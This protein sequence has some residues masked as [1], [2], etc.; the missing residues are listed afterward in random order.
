MRKI[1][2]LAFSLL[3]FLFSLSSL[4]SKIYAAAEDL[5]ASS[6]SK[7]EVNYEL[8]YPGLLPDNPLYFLRA[9]R[10]RVVSFL[11]ADP[12]K[13]AEFNLLQADK[14]LNAGIYLFDKNKV[15]LSISTISKAEN[16]FEEAL[17]KTREA[18]Q[19][20]MVVSDIAGR[21]RD[22][23]RKHQKE[24]YLLSQKSP[25]SFKANFESQRKR[26]ANFEIEAESLRLK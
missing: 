20:G 25:Q 12:K 19:Q 1:C 22:S 24:I 13:K 14:R 16:Y 26:T 21:L 5:S 23:S 7:S 11:I 3:V 10:D 15:D 17:Q 4:S 8:P 2:L 6:S 9:V 18:S